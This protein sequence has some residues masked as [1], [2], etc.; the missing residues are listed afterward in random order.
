MRLIDEQGIVA[1][2]VHLLK[3]LFPTF[4]SGC[5]WPENDAVFFHHDFQRIMNGVFFQHDFGKLLGQAVFCGF[6]G[7]VFSVSFSRIQ[8]TDCS[9]LGLR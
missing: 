6:H 8:L 9:C 2:F 3:R 5:N 1:V 7:C 4:P